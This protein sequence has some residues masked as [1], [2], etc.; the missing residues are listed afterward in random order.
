MSQVL[1]QQP[2]RAGRTAARGRER[3]S[4]ADLARCHPIAKAMALNHMHQHMVRVR[5]QIFT[6]EHDEPARELLAHLGWLLGIGAEVAA[7][8]APGT[9][10]AKRLHAA[11]RMVVDMARSG[12][13]WQA[14]L[15]AHLDTEAQAA[16]QLMV[17][18]PEVAQQLIA[19]ADYL[20]SRIS[21][22][23][24]TLDD[25]AGADVYQST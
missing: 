18:H 11:L 8:V 17:A 20:S 10:Q 3:R 4:Q 19:G 23:T 25:V 5:L 2:R 12:A 14:H 1:V 15:A 22:G 9:H 6:R 7:N 13:R 21:A 24:V 16:H